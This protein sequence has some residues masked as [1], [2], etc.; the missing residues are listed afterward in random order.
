MTC[1]VLAQEREKELNQLQFQ[2]ISENAW[3]KRSSSDPSLT[4]VGV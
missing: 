2:P 4:E 3:L 1:G